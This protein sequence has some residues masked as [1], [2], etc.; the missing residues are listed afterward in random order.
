MA[1]KQKL[2]KKEQILLTRFKEIDR[3]IYTLCG[4]SAMLGWDKQTLMPEAASNDRAEQSSYL[5][6]KIH[7]LFTSKEFKATTNA[8]AKPDTIK[9]LSNKEQVL[10]KH[11]KKE[12][13]K[14]SKI[15]ESFVKEF[16]KLS[17]KSYSQWVKAREKKDYKLFAPFME[18]LIKMKK[19]EA[20]LIN[21]KANAYDLI[22][23]DFE[24][25]MTQATIDPVFQELRDGIIALLSQIKRSKKYKTQKNILK[26]LDFPADKQMQICKEIIQLML[27]ED[28]RYKVAESVHPFTTRLSYDDVRLTTAYRKGMPLFSFTSASHEAGHALY[29]LGMDKKLKFTG[30]QDSPSFGLH[31][32][33]SRLWENQIMRGEDFWKGYYSKYQKTFPALKKMKFQE[34]FFQS[35][36]VKPSLIRI[37][38]DELT[39]CLHVIIRYELEKQIFKGE[40]KTK[41]LEQAWNNK[42]HEYLG[43]TPKHATE[44][45]LQ[46]VHWAE[47]IFGYFP[48]Y[49]IGTLYSAM[50]FEQMQKDIPTLKKEL[51][52][53]NI[54]SAR[55]W[56]K[57]KVHK[58]G[59]EMTSEQIIFKA[60]GKHLTARPFLDYLKKKYYTL[61]EIKV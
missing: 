29:E 12:I 31:E 13:K 1:T 45:I 24:T 6:T 48:T 32:S 9:K 40:I 56:L 43:V 26:K 19:E 36:Q 33:Q 28:K 55:S 21:S 7:S 17:S 41:D 16:S 5:S 10:I 27:Q 46:D 20:N 8:L 39:Y 25:G 15:P 52:K 38:C 3:E 50:L 35:N 51:R 47:G 57:E 4:I 18:K 37:E 34:F 59:R 14:S 61:Y 44:G 11:Y 30:L 58:Y 23:D 60:T 42:Y 22:V 49:A 54:A 2:T 53:G